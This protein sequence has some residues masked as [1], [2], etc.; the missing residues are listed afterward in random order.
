[1]ESNTNYEIWSDGG[2]FLIFFQGKL[3]FLLYGQE[4][5][6]GIRGIF[7]FAFLLM[8]VFLN[9]ESGVEF[10]LGFLPLYLIHFTSFYDN[11]SRD[12]IEKNATSTWG[13]SKA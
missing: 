1:M 7:L 10:F 12:M 6:A 2:Q 3:F 5:S 9:V 4:G 11:G 8:L 13:S